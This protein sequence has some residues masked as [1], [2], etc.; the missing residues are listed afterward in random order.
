MTSVELAT[1]VAELET[2]DARRFELEY[3]FKVDPSQ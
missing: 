1:Y 3:A 2:I